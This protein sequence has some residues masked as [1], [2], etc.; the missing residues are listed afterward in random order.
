MLKDKDGLMASKLQMESF[1]NPHY[2][3]VIRDLEARI[4]IIEEKLQV[5]REKRIEVKQHCDN[6]NHFTDEGQYYQPC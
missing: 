6:V 3:G 2:D 5:L 1:R 4:E